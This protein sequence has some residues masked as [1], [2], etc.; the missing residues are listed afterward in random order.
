MAQQVI[1]GTVLDAV[2]EA[3]LASANISIMDTALGTS[4]DGEGRFSLEV[5][6]LPVTLVVRFVGYIPRRIPVETGD[7]VTVLLEP[8][9]IRLEDLVVV[10]SRLDP[11]TVID[12]PVPVD[13]IKASDLLATGQIT[14]DK[15]LAYTVPAF[16]STQQTVSDATAHF[17]P[18]DLRGLGPSRTLVLVNGKRK[19]YSALVYI[20][21]TPGKGEV[22]VDMKSIPAAA[23]ER[24]EVLRDGASSQYGSDAIAGVINVVLKD[25]VGRTD[26]HV[27]SGGTTQGDGETIGYDVNTGFALGNRG[28]LNLT[29]SFSDRKETQRAGVPCGGNADIATC[30]G[31]FGGLLGLV[32]TPEAQA[33][34]RANPDLGMRVGAPNMTTADI[35][36]NGAV[37]VADNTEVYGFG[38]LTWR[39]GLSYALHRTPYWI[40]DPHNV[41]HAPG[42][43]YQGFHPT[44]ETWILDKTFAL[45]VRGQAR[46]WQFDLSDT[47][48]SNKVDYL[49]DESLNT[50][51]GAQTPVRFDVGGY[52]FRNNV[53]NL[54]MSRRM[55][56]LHVAIGSEFRTENFVA[57]AGEDASW[58]GSGTQ[59]FPGLQPQNEVDET[60]YNIGVYGDVGLD[61]N[62]HLLVGG[63][64]R[65]ENYSDF[66]SDVS[67]KLN[68]RHRLGDMGSLR[69][70]ASTGFRAPSLH[71]IY[72]SN[73][74]TLLSGGTVSNQGTFNNASPAIKALQIPSLK[75]ENAFNVTGG[76]ALQPVPGLYL[77][78]DAY[79]VNVDDRIVYT[80]SIASDDPNTAVGRIQEQFSI[81]SLKLF[82]NAVNTRTQGLDLV[83]QYEFETSVGEWSIQLGGNVNQTEIEGQIATPAPIAAAN[84][85]IFD[86]KE[87]SRILSARP[88]DKIIAGVRYEAGRV[89]AT[90]NNT[91]FGTVTWQHASD[92]DKDQTFSAR[93]VT[94]LDAE[95]RVRPQIRFGISIHNLFDVYPDEIDTKGDPLTNLGG[96]FR[97]PWEV[98]QFGFD[99]TIIMGSVRVTL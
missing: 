48:G 43:T 98:N 65:F 74:Q 16:N 94:D 21:D 23:I 72:L 55:D 89:R 27:F 22:G 5:D 32:N 37:Q 28:F 69:L 50:D 88:G 93:I 61:V 75:Q 1:S 84:V 46:G 25:D 2:T 30:D 45:G 29:H 96:R 80:S 63:A 70:S 38:G 56:Q 60:R 10:G 54:D 7:P 34:V 66:G 42:T 20:N 44:F 49:V 76:I 3:P 58:A 67:W 68:G 40:P 11:R 41:Y 8:E 18:A 90:L 39:K 9:E 4:T 97:Y 33:W 95:I 73:I 91:R 82:T 99:G 59:S 35:F 6:A 57:N 19:S 53:V 64:L 31:L 85:D 77:S 15:M 52:E 26:V 14:F 17:D 24:V 87:Q 92:P 47:Q 62:E 81:T 79:M 86:R 12:S 83:M 51:L 78:V 13:N 71:Q 36:Y